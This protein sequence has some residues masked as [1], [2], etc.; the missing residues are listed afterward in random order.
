[1]HTPKLILPLVL[2]LTTSTGCEAAQTPDA[3][4]IDES[5]DE[6][7]GPAPSAQSCPGASVD[8]FSWSWSFDGYQPEVAADVVLEFELDGATPLECTVSSFGERADALIL[9]LNCAAGGVITPD[10]ELTVSPV[11]PSLLADLEQDMPMEVFFQPQAQC[12]NACNFAA[13]AGWLSIR[14]AAD[15]ALR[16]GI[17]D[18]H[19]LLSPVEELSPLEFATHTVS[20]SEVDDESG[21]DPDGWTQG[22]D[23]T[24]TLAGESQTLVRTG[25]VSFGGYRVLL[26]SAVTGA[27]DGCTADGGD[28]AQ[29]QMMLFAEDPL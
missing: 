19:N 17:I 16:L 15:G 29:I 28:R 27:Y 24:V 13:P 1:M 21:C 14:H 5:N 18:A 2:A 4:P 8:A 9:G 23:F 6:P 11:P 3:D 22:L 10:Q 20:C 7:T 12:N 25:D 26:D